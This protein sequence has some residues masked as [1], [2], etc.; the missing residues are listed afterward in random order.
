MTF[1]M[2]PPPDSS[3][4]DEALMSRLRDD[5]ALRSLCPDGVWWDVGDEKSKRFIV[6]S[7]VDHSDVPVYGGRAWENVLYLVKAVMLNSAGGSVRAAAARIDALLE[8]WQ[9]DLVGFGHLSCNREQRIRI[10]ETDSENSA[11]RWL[12]R[13]G[14]YRAHASVASG[15]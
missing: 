9:T 5:S 10:T 3:I 8:D 4:V 15:A 6:I 14:R 7:I 12:H 11:V 1:P 2:Q 13:G